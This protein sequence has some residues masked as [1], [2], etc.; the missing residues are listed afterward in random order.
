MISGSFAENDL[1]RKASSESSKESSTLGVGCIYSN[2][3]RLL[4]FIG[5][6]GKRAQQKRIYS[7]KETYNWKEP[8]NRSHPIPLAWDAFIAIRVVSSNV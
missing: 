6:F 4:K 8:T 3:S 5:L 1:H 7:A 2:S